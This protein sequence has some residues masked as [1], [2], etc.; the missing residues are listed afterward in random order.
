MV[1]I[2]VHTPALVWKTSLTVIRSKTRND[3]LRVGQGFA[4]RLK[5][6][7]RSVRTTF[8]ARD[9]RV[10]TALRDSTAIRNAA[11]PAVR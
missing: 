10:L 9:C 1:V 6:I 7:F 8:R 3:S 2:K 5:R 4:F 11:T